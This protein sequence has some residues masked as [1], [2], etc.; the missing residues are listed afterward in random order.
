MII[1]TNY[2]YEASRVYRLKV[3]TIEAI[4]ITQDIIE[5]LYQNKRQSFLYWGQ[6][7]IEYVAHSHALDIK[8]NGGFVLFHPGDYLAKNEYG[9]LKHFDRQMFLDSWEPNISD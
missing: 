8:I 4:C 3:P 6:S 5:T 9:E 2:G 1:T 7:L